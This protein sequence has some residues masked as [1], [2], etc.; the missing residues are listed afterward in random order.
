MTRIYHVL[1]LAAVAALVLGIATEIIAAPAEAQQRNIPASAS[2]DDA[3]KGRELFVKQGCYQCHGYVGQGAIATG[4]TLVPGRLDENGFRDYVRSP[5]GVMPAY[6][7]KII[8]GEAIGLLMRYVRSL[9]QGRP[10]SAIPLLAP[11]VANLAADPSTGGQLYLAHCAACHGAR[12]DGGVGPDLRQE[13][14]KRDAAAT[15]WLLLNPPPRMPKLSPNPL[16]VEQMRSIAVYVR[17][18]Q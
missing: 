7:S 2:S 9:P 4:P 8:S 16:A 1:V 17:S 6:T 3:V 18:V 5:E 13:A 15:L 10:P 14:A 11:Y 12:R